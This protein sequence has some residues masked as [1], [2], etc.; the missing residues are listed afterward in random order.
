MAGPGISTKKYPK[1]GFRKRGRRNGVASDFSVFFI[2]RFLPF[3]SVSFRFLPFSS[4]SFLFLPFHFQKKTGRHRS[5]DPF[6]ETPK[7]E[8]SRPSLKYVSKKCSVF[9]CLDQGMGET[10]IPKITRNG[11]KCPQWRRM[12]TNRRLIETNR[13]LIGD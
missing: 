11:R 1:F 5:R 6:C 4:V 9:H 3:S 7:I 8:C 12:A 13:R 2:F 10:T